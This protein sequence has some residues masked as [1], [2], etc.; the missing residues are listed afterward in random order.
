MIPEDIA[1]LALLLTTLFFIIIAIELK[2][3]IKS[4]ISL[5]IGSAL[6]AII[7]YILGA[8]I[9]AIFELSVCAG[10]VTVLLLSAIGMFENKEES[11]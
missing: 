5:G 7:F 11:K 8:P 10:L 6:L 3:L 1:T 2:N 9:A 4:S